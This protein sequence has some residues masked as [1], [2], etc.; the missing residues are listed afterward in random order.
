[1]DPV[2]SI[3][4]NQ[5]FDVDGDGTVTV[6][7]INGINQKAG[8]VEGHPFYDPAYDIDNDKNIGSDDALL[9][10]SQYGKSCSQIGVT[11]TTIPSATTTVPGTLSIVSSCADVDGNGRIEVDDIL[12]VSQ[13]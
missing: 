1:M 9:A 5:C 8:I 13:R 6:S 11:T 10:N 2:P 12:A 7:D 4:V 3:S